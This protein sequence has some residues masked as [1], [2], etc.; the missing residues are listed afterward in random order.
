MM[1]K[2]K[3]AWRAITPRNLKV[4]WSGRAKSPNLI[5]IAI[6]WAGLKVASILAT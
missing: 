1:M 4:R 5:G 6:I 3:V 2:K